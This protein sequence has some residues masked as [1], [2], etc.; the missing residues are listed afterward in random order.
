MTDR[1]YCIAI[2]SILN[3]IYPCLIIAEPVDTRS[4]ADSGI[5]SKQSDPPMFGQQ[6]VSMKDFVVPDRKEAAT[7]I[8]SPNPQKPSPNISKV[9]PN[10]RQTAE[11]EPK[12]SRYLGKNEDK[13]IKHP[14]GRSSLMSNNDN[15]AKVSEETNFAIFSLSDMV[16]LLAVLALILAAA[17]VVKRFMPGKRLWTGSGV[18]EVVARTTLSSRQTLVLVKMGQRLILLGVTSDRISTLTEVTDPEEIAMLVGRIA[19]QQSESMTQAFAQ[20]FDQEATAFMDQTDSQ[21]PAVAAQGQVRGLLE[22]VRKLTG[23]RDVA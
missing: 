22:K 21:D 4:S 6:A 7:E 8:Q 17:W 5:V 10:D 11:Q 13:P 9:L 1:R 23:N 12:S 20:S 14:S 19:S 3:L 15:K 2:F 18:M 16:P